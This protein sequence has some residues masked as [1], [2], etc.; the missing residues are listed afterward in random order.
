[1]ALKHLKPA[2]LPDRPVADRSARVQAIRDAGGT[3]A[4]LAQADLRRLARA[5]E[6]VTPEVCAPSPDWW[7]RV[8][9]QRHQQCD[10][11]P[12]F[13]GNCEKSP[14]EGSRFEWTDTGLETVPC[15]RWASWQTR[16]FLERRGVEK[17]LLHATL[18]NY[19]ARSKGHAKAL[20][21]C[22]RFVEGYVGRTDGSSLFLA[23][24]TGLGKSHLATGVLRA[25][26]KRY[27]VPGR[28]VFV[29][30]LLSM[31]K[32]AFRDPTAGR[33]YEACLSDEFLVIDDLGVEQ[34][35]EWSRPQLEVLLH[36]R[37][38]RNL[39]TCVTTNETPETL[40]IRLAA[41]TVRRILDKS[42][43]FRVDLRGDYRGY[44]PE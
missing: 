16:N 27:R 40:A 19:E 44:R 32:E 39:A 28:F 30:T 29:P 18:G 9:D 12:Q 6:G 33:L 37:D 41:R 5:S 21:L 14:E 1:M 3:R 34:I 22:R 17:G 8:A 25:L 13:G 36:E 42:S 7:L 24:D 35:T 2:T 43:E 38:A 4:F 15:D 20:D 23:G 26:W 10:N 11:C 31:Q